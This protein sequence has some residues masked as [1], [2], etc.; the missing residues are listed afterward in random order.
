MLKSILTGLVT[1]SQFFILGF[2]IPSYTTGDAIVDPHNYVDDAIELTIQD[3]YNTYVTDFGIQ[4]VT[5]V[6]NTATEDNKGQIASSIISEWE[7]NR[8]VVTV[9]NPDTQVVGSAMTSDV[10]VDLQGKTN[11]LTVRLS[12][13]LA[14]DNIELGLLDYYSGYPVQSVTYAELNIPDNSYESRD[15]SEEETQSQIVVDSGRRQLSLFDYVAISIGIT[16]VV[17]GSIYGVYRYQKISRL[18]KDIEVFTGFVKS[19]PEFG[20][21]E[22]WDELRSSGDITHSYDD[23]KEYIAKNYDGS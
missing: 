6:D 17:G 12:Q 20:R 19:N 16:V 1:V 5:V 13:V 21:R 4:L 2:T 22:I 15:I 3:M 23:Y 18:T 10:G 11:S 9:V 7:L 8:A 14:E